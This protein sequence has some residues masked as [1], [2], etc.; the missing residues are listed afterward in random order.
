MEIYL[1]QTGP[2][3]TYRDSSVVADDHSSIVRRCVSVRSF[4]EL[5]AFREIESRQCIMECL[6]PVGCKS[7][8]PCR[9]LISKTHMNE[10]LASEDGRE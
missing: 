10:D 5:T 8:M 3:R 9:F 7:W 6:A 2:H 1:A 4:R